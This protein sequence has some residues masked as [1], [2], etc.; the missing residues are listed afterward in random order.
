[1]CVCTSLLLVCVFP[2]QT[3]HCCLLLFVYLST[4]SGC[5]LVSFFLFLHFLVTVYCRLLTVKQQVQGKTGNVGDWIV[6]L[7]FL[8]SPHISTCSLLLLLLLCLAL[9]ISRPMNTRQ[10]E[11]GDGSWKWSCNRVCRVQSED[12]K[13]SRG[14]HSL[15]AC[16]CVWFWRSAP[17]LILE[18]NGL[19]VESN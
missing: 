13:V 10:R 9:V 18:V 17:W 1:M 8:F 7:P 16:V 6:S 11:T 3:H 12:R 15:W 5:N 4:A 19:K 14:N 2:P